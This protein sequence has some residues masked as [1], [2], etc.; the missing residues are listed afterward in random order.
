MTDFSLFTDAQL[1]AAVTRLQAEFTELADEGYLFS[2]IA[3]RE[4]VELVRFEIAM[5]REAADWQA[6]A[7]AYVDWCRDHGLGVDGELQSRIAEMQSHQPA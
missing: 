3:R 4:Q 2:A 1:E 7:D 5:R 6:R